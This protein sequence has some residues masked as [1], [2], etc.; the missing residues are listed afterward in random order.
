MT[1]PLD[2]ED[3]ADDLVIPEECL[4]AVLAGMRPAE[5]GHFGKWRE[6]GVPHK[7]WQCIDVYELDRGEEQTCEMC[8]TASIH[9]VHVMRHPNY[10]GEL[11][12]GK[13]CA[14]HMQQDLARAREREDEFKRQQKELK[15]RQKPRVAAALSWVAAADEI[16]AVGRTEAWRAYEAWDL[17][18]KILAVTPTLPPG[19]DDL[20][21]A[22]YLPPAE[23]WPPTVVGLGFN[24]KLVLNE[25]ERDFVCDMRSRAQHYASPRVRKSFAPT[26]NQKKWFKALYLRMTGQT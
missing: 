23:G 22:D 10:E 13:I 26:F 24:N 19:W 12:V 17:R 11:E 7:G 15:R 9:T 25:R 5:A 20:F 14:G 4:D 16:L 2:V 6:R 18:R 21:G 1:A 8:E 3:G